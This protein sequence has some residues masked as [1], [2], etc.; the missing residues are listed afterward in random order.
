MNSRKSHSEMLQSEAF[1]VGQSTALTY[2]YP[3]VEEE[4]EDAARV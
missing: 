4:A 2:Q 3:F 1:S